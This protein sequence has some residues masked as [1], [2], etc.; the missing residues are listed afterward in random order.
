MATRRILKIVV[1]LIMVGLLI[2]RFYYLYPQR[3]ERLNVLFITI[4]ALR[5]DH[6]GCYGYGRD[7]SPMIDRLAREGVVFTQAISQASYTTAS[8]PSIFTSLYPMVHKVVSERIILADEFLTLAEVLKANDFLTAAFMPSS[9]L[10][11]QFVFGQGFEFYDNTWPD[12]DPKQYPRW[13]VFDTASY[14]GKKVITFMEKKKAEPFFLYLHYYDVHSPYAPPPPYESL[15]YNPKDLNK[16]SQEQYTRIPPGIR[17]KNDHQDLN[18]YL[19][20]YDG[21][22]RYMDEQI[23]ILLEKL[24]E[25]GLL[26]QTMIIIT[27][28]HGE[29]FLDHGG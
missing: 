18:F 5:P 10:K 8:I 27:A 9:I 1:M 12:L 16:F 7:T 23:K 21:G 3:Q 24:D 17:V 14:I 22:I 2:C 4:D 25:M 6:L 28:D 15:F 13:K 26:E 20:L 11:A 29:E 19:A